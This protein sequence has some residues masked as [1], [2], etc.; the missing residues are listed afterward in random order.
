MYLEV[1]T[2]SGDQWYVRLVGGNG[3]TMMFSEMY[4]SKDN[5][6]RAAYN[7]QNNWPALIEVKVRV[8]ED[9]V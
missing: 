2:K 5:A 4:Y 3:E 9:A 1:T 6:E 7:I 8:G